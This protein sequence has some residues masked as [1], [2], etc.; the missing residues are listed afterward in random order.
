MACQLQEETSTPLTYYA[1][2][3]EKELVWRPGRAAATAAAGSSQ[4]G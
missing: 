1:W 4:E 2:E 3:E